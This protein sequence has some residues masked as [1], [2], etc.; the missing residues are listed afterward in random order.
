MVYSRVYSLDKIL[1][2]NVV[3]VKNC[4]ITYY[5][6]KLQLSSYL[7]VSCRYSLG[8]FSPRDGTPGKRERPSTRDSARTSR[9]APQRARF[10]NR[11]C[12]SQRMLYA[13]VC[14]GRMGVLHC[15]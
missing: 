4:E 8:L 6:Y 15:S 3:P 1:F 10:R 13:I 9:R 12:R 2:P 11:N 7:P 5:V 14:S